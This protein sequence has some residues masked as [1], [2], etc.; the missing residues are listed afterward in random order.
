MISTTLAGRSD[1]SANGARLPSSG[2][3]T[4]SGKK[5]A[6]RAVASRQLFMEENSLLRE[7]NPPFLFP[8]AHACGNQRFNPAPMAIIIVC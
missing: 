3:H 8:N 6:L 1:V 7:T 5:I 2:R 4:A